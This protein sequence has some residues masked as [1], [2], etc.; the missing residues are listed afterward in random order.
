MTHPTCRQCLRKAPRHRL[1]C[2]NS[3]E[4]RDRLCPDCC[5]HCDWV[6]GYHHERCYIEKRHLLYPDVALPPSR[7]NG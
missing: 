5:K 3:S 1:G 7:R 2:P 6:R 4:A